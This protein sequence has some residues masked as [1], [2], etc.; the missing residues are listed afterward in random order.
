M[1]D[2]HFREVCR[3]RGQNSK[4]LEMERAMLVFHWIDLYIADKC[5]LG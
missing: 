3:F 5:H 4:N 2:G 1:Y